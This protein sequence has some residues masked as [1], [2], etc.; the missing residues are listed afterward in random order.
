MLKTL[1]RGRPA[2]D[3]F[4]PANNIS[5]TTHSKMSNFKKMN[6]HDTCFLNISV[7]RNTYLCVVLLICVCVS[8]LVYPPLNGVMSLMLGNYAKY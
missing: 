8:Y 4:Q 5:L 2:N 1:V 3:Y 6:M 7:C